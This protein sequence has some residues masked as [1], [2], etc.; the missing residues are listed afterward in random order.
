MAKDADPRQ[1]WS[2]LE[3]D[4][5]RGL[6]P[7]YVLKC[8]EP[9]FGVRALSLLIGKAR[10]AG[11]EVCR[12]D[13]GEG[14]F[15]AASLFD[16]LC[17][18]AMFDSARCI[19]VERPDE[20]LR[21]QG[22]EDAPLTR[23]ARAFLEARRGTLVLV[24][25]GLRADHALVKAVRKSGGEL[26]AFRALWD[27]PPPWNPDP[28][29][30]ELVGWISARATELGLRLSRDAALWLSKAKGNDLSALDGE[31]ANLVQAGPQAVAALSSEAAGSPRKLADLLADG[32]RGG[33]LLEIERLW[34]G[35][36]DKGRG[37]GRET[38][39]AAILAVLFG[40]LRGN[41]RQA[42]MGSAALAAGADPAAAADAAGVPTWPKARAG[43]A[44]RVRRQSAARWLEMQREAQVLERRSRGA[45]VVD[46]NDLAA[47]ALR[48][49]RPAPGV[50][51]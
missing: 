44:A 28:T 49:G 42:L 39:G 25:G 17:G 47:F 14:G 9:W 35:G 20:L 29:Q 34:Q 32:D 38:S 31:L 33:A 6:A 11:L 4:V 19:V 37:A 7:G 40:S 16:D 13:A 18:N 51:R 8:E 45:A 12:H 5:A 26:Y 36:F 3:A 30:S 41:L 23:H 48:W 21:K 46:A 24:A 15:R 10:A 2:A 50:R 43:F 22:A 27:S 1:V